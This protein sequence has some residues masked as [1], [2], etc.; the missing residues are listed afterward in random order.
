MH[1][2][3]SSVLLERAEEAGSVFKCLQCKSNSI[4]PVKLLWL[5]VLKY[6]LLRTGLVLHLQE[7]AKIGEVSTVKST[8]ISVRDPA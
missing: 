2:A 7:Q 8:V 1:K 4:M 3:A 6:A 5:C